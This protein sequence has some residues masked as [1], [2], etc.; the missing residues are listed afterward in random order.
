MARTP[1]EFPGERIDEGLLLLPTIVLP[2]Q[3]G[4]ILYASG[5]ISGSG[6][7][8]CEENKIIGPLKKFV[9]AEDTMQI[10][11]HK[12]Y[13]AFASLVTNANNKNMLAIVND[14]GSQEVVRIEAIKI[15]N[16]TTTS[17]TG[18]AAKF[19][20]KRITGVS[21]ATVVELQPHDT[22]DVIPLSIHAYTG[23]TVV[24]ESMNT[25]NRWSWSTDEWGPGTLDMEGNQLIVQNT[26]VWETKQGMKP[27][28]IR[29]GQG[30]MIVFRGST[31]AGTHDMLVEF[32]LA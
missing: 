16:T 11:E 29:A 9:T 14:L 19:E 23:G 31:S 1:D 8:F 20:L 5:T 22:N 32:T 2:E 7:F 24:G 6:F 13:A 26:F 10:L 15:I 12:T 28:V 21:D 4:E 30:V 3:V 27:Y 25:L 17:V 18:I